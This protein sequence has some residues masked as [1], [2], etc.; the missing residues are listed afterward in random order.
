MP[1][2]CSVDEHKKITDFGYD[3]YCAW[4][5]AHVNEA[6]TSAPNCRD[7][8]PLHAS[9]GLKFCPDCGEKL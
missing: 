3:P 1:K 4:C 8:H 5:G 7:D 9:R 2:K 6:A